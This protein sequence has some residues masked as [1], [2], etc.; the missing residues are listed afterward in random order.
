MVADQ[1]VLQYNILPL[2]GWR[3]NHLIFLK[4]DSSPPQVTVSFI[5]VQDYMI[6]RLKYKIKLIKLE[7]RNTEKY[8]A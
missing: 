3:N 7:K 4:E 8:Q 5:E 6:S 2:Q 1:A